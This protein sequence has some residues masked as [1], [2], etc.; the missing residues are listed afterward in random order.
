M[1]R[2]TSE[3]L[4]NHLF[5]TLEALQEGDIDTDKAKGVTDIAKTIIDLEKA[6]TDQHR[7]KLDTVKLIAEHNGLSKQKE[8][9]LLG[10]E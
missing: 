9:Y 1:P 5:A 4:K 8:E 2:N 3:D 6:K 10:G 7:L